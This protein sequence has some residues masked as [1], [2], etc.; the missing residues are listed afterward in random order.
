MIP[1][2]VVSDEG[3]TIKRSPTPPWNAYLEYSEGERT[4]HYHLEY[5]MPGSV[6][7]I[8]VENIGPWLSPHDAEEISQSQQELIATRIVEAMIYWGDKAEKV[9]AH[10][11]L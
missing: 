8:I 11:K 2:G 1:G 6:D 10:K 3:F 9:H 5:L 4:L 7:K